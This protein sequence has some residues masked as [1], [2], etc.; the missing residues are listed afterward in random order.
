VR[1]WLILIRIGNVM[2][3]GM[4]SVGI[5]VRMGKDGVMMKR[6]VSI[7]VN[8]KRIRED[9]LLDFMPEDESNDIMADEHRG[10]GGEYE[11]G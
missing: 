2:R 10:D 7:A 9:S 5:V 6:I 8:S 1:L 11:T 4:K 3:E